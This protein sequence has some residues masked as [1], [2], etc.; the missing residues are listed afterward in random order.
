MVSGKKELFGLFS[1]GFLVWFCIFTGKARPEVLE[2][3]M[4]S[5]ADELVRIKKELDEK[6]KSMVRLNQM[7]S[8]AFAAF[9]DLEE[10]LELNEKLLGRLTFR[11]G[12][13][14]R[15]LEGR[16]IDLKET[17]QQLRSHREHS[18]RRLREIYKHGRYEL[19][20]TI[21]GTYSPLGLA[22]RLR[23]AERIMAED[24]ETLKA[25][26]ALKAGL[27]EKREDLGKT[28]PEVAWLR[29]RR[30]EERTVHQ[31]TLEEK[32]SL[33][34]KIRSE[35]KLCA[36]EIR[37]LEED[38]SEIHKILG[39]LRPEEMYNRKG[40]GGR[41]SWFET[42][43]G[44]LL[45]PIEG[46]VVSHFGE[47]RHPR[48]HTKT[49]NLGVEI[50][51]E[52]GTEVVAVAEGRVIYVS[53]LRGYGSFLIL[54]HDDQYHTIYAH[55]SEILITPG[56]DVERS[57]RI[58]SVGEGGPVLAPSLYFEIRKGKQPTDPL[59]WLK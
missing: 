2:T 28:R 38:A 57:Q 8:D 18:A 52:V 36:Q 59:E 42:L 45:W 33:L 16:E 39:R 29:M 41:E 13:I 14:Q 7:E 27:E 56:E 46:R 15:E 37:V 49:E 6:R 54:K 25:T 50:Q 44:K 21:F 23:S 24:Q 35:K 55:L 20:A 47:Q 10:R 9:L 31:R 26:E 58:G 1:L 4:R 3:E 34:K 48:F 53:R 32:E 19:C 11:E 51:A 17:E 43:R 22:G 30:A 40:G 5:Q 12:S